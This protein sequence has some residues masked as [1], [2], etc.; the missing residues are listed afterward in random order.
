MHRKLGQAYLR[1]RDLA[2]CKRLQDGVHTTASADITP[3]GTPVLSFGD[4]TQRKRDKRFR[5]KGSCQPGSSCLRPVHKQLIS[6]Q[7]RRQKS[8]SNK[9]E[10]L[11][12][13]STLQNG[14][15]FSTERSV[16]TKRLDGQAGSKG[17]VLLCL[18]KRGFQ[19]VSSLQVGKLHKGIQ[20]LSNW[21]RPSSSKI[22]KPVL[23]FL[24]KRGMRLIIYKDGIIILNQNQQDLIK[25]RDTVIFIL[26]FWGL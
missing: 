18:N 17:C 25:D 6:G 5:V 7:K 11:C 22:F 9:S 16:E 14:R 4:K 1:S 12:G 13:V 24:R 3:T 20:L 19:A 26:Q 21:I 2:D 8:A 10:V 23:A 15:Y